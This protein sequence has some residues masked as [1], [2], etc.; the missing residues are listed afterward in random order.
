MKRLLSIAKIVRKKCEKFAL[1]KDSIDYDF[2]GEND[3]TCMCAVAS[4]ALYEALRQ[5]GI[6]CKV[7]EGLF[8]QFKEEPRNYQHYLRRYS[9]CWV[10]AGKKVIDITAT[11]FGDYPKVHVVSNKNKKYRSMKT[12][13]DY[14]YFNDWYGQ[15][16]SETVSKKIL[17]L[18]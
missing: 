9:H 6:T 14:N 4:F 8:Y 2:N 18:P 12:I 3:L 11:Q 16:P 10:K 7:V 5:Q 17:T 13:T 15:T 1:S